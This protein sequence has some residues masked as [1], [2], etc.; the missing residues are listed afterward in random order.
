LN[1]FSP[2]SLRL[3]RFTSRCSAFALVF[4]SFVSS[5]GGQVMLVADFFHPIDRLAI[6]PFLNGYV[7]H[8]CVWCSPMPMF[9]PRLEPDHITRPNVLDWTTPTLY[10]PTAS[11]YNQGLAQRMGVPCSPSTRLERDTGAYCACRIR[12]LEQRIDAY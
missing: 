8:G 2:Q 7:R 3:L 11:R 10:A 12:R 1:A 5:S 9:L 4:V 6:E